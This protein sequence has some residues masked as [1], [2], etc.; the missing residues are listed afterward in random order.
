[1]VPAKVYQLARAWECRS[2]VEAAEE[3]LWA[4]PSRWAQARALGSVRVKACLSVSAW[5]SE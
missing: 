5:E 2:V 1:L 4:T 3:C